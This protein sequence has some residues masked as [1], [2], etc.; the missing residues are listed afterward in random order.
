VVGAPR[1]NRVGAETLDRQL[2]QA[3]R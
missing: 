3:T 2:D 1:Q